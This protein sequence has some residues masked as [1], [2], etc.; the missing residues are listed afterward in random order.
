MAYRGLDA[1]PPNDSHQQMIYLRTVRDV[2]NNML[3]GK[4]NITLDVTLTAGAATTVIN[5]PRIGGTS[6]LSLD[7]PLT[8]N[9]AAEIGNGTI[10]VS[11]IGNKTATLTHA[12]NAQVDRTFRIGIMG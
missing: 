5:D 8:A 3:I 9:A 11:S 10:Y 2:V 1:A 4:Q 12:N 6:R 7:C